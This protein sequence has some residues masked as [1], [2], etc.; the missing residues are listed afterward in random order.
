MKKKYQLTII[1]TFTLSLLANVANANNGN[2][3]QAL[4]AIV[5]TLLNDEARDP[6]NCQ[7][8]DSGGT[9]I[10]SFDPQEGIN[11]FIRSSDLS[12][13]QGFTR[14]EGDLLLQ[15]G[16]GDGDVNDDDGIN[17]NAQLSLLN[18][19][20]EVTGSITFQIRPNVNFTSVENVFP[21]LKTI[22]GSLLLNEPEITTDPLITDFD[23]F[24]SLE[25]IGEALF[26]VGN[27]SIER[28]TGFD[29]LTNP[30]GNGIIV[31]NINFDCQN[32][33]PS[34]FSTIGSSGNEVD[35]N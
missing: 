14:V 20:V 24:V 4:P 31:D 25:T 19:L 26:L 27:N 34:I 12:Q 32:D 1:L 3:T 7:D 8:I 11:P 18:S 33:A 5:F 22:G 30:D 21:C 16:P 13:F 28:I 29:N 10:T 23:G 17:S 15:I 6:T 2:V 35:C 9:I